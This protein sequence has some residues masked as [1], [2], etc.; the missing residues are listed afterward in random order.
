MAYELQLYTG[1][2]ERS[3]STVR[4][5][6]PVIDLPVIDVP[7]IDIPT[8]EMSSNDSNVVDADFRVIE[9]REKPQEPEDTIN[10]NR[11]A[12][13]LTTLSLG[14][15][16]VQSSFAGL[17]GEFTTLT[18]SLRDISSFE[19]LKKILGRQFGNRFHVLSMFW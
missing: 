5:L 18:S 3:L 17:G 16:T 6:M 1:G 8:I 14:I 7:V 9:T 13:S 4:D 12:R 11:T 2:L 19:D 10:W 15:G